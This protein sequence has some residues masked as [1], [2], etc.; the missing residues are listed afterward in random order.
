MATSVLWVLHFLTTYLA[1]Q[2]LIAAEAAS[3]SCR[4]TI[5]EKAPSAETVS[6]AVA[7]AATTW[8]SH[9][10]RPRGVAAPKRLPFTKAVVKEVP[11]LSLPFTHIA[12]VAMADTS[13]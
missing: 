3:V 1:V 9:E 4:V 5:V 6:A 13:R 2:A 12:R 11:R 8:A 7:A 10:W